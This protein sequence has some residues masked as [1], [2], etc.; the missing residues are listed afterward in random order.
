MRSHVLSICAT[1]IALVSPLPSAAQETV[2]RREATDP[3]QQAIELVAGRAVAAE[4]LKDFADR[5]PSAALDERLHGHLLDA[6][7]GAKYSVRDA[8]TKQ[9]SSLIA[10]SHTDRHL[11]EVAAVL[12]VSD[13]IVRD[14]DAVCTSVPTPCR[15]G[16]YSALIAF[17]P[18]TLVRDLAYVAVKLGWTNLPA[19]RGTIPQ[20]GSE[21]HMTVY[22]VLLASDGTSW[23]VQSISR[24][25]VN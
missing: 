4:L 16:K 15:M 11:A 1:V 8:N 20:A 10:S 9:D 18:A 7:R 24:V 19:A 21:F 17:S 25:A 5:L 23:K 14:R 2:V 6:P 13:R 22:R 3:Q 12:G